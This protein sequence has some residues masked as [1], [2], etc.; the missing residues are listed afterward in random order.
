MLMIDQLLYQL[1]LQRLFV[2]IKVFYFQCDYNYEKMK[3]NS[4]YHFDNSI[5]K[6]FLWLRSIL[7]LLL[8]KINRIKV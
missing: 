1:I 3:K 4:S 5:E 2:F 7:F 8:K 6:K